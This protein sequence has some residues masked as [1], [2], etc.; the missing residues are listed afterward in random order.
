MTHTPTSWI[1]SIFTHA[2][3]LFT[4]HYKDF[5]TTAA[6]L[7]GIGYLLL[8]MIPMQLIA[9]PV[10]GAYSYAFAVDGSLE[11]MMLHSLLQF[12]IAILGMYMTAAVFLQV[13]S[14][15][16]HHRA[17]G[18]KKALQEAGEMLFGI[19]GTTLLQI[20]FL[21]GLLLLLIIPGIIFLVYWVFTVY[22]VVHYGKKRRAALDESKRIV[23][24]RRWKTVG[25]MIVLYLPMIIISACLQWW[26]K[27]SYGLRWWAFFPDL[28][29]NGAM[30]VMQVFYS[31]VASLFFL[32]WDRSRIGATQQHQHT[33]VH[34][35]EA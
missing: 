9:T 2:W 11:L 19:L 27:A 23:K 15:V 35:H 26:L 30:L 34:H 16:D 14:F 31:I 22:V 29:H 3:H 33:A 28:I 4:T 10:Q 7:L 32:Q 13:R 12:A 25:Y 18:W 20:L 21:F 24:W 8:S 17:L 1:W 6:W 5:L